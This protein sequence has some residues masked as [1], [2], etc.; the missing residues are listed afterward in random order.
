MEFNTAMSQAWKDHADD[1]RGVA[2]RLPALLPLVDD[3]AQLERLVALTHHVHGTHL[4]QW[5]AGAEALA[6]LRTLNAY[7]DDGR[8]G[9]ALRRALASLALC[10]GKMPATLPLSLSDQVRV[11]AMAAENLGEHDPARA[12]QLF[13]TTLDLAQRSG[14]PDSDA[15]HRAIA[16]TANGLA[17]ALEAK[18]DRSADD[19]ALMILA[20]QA[21][22][23][24]WERAGTWLEV[25]RAEYRL[26]M[27]WLQ[28]GDL[29]Q[30]RQHG[31]TCREIVAENNGGALER[32]FGWEAL[33]RVER[34]AD[35]EV[36]HAHA[37]AMA[38]EAFSELSV[39][40]QAW[41]AASLDQLAAAA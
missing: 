20:A 12:G 13:R 15:M 37:L 1:A 35:N 33:G 11:H 21:A 40:D 16:I 28:A 30:A 36:G 9:Q 29:G 14:L 2:I 23:R 18:T 6:P 31:Q 27:S 5:Q 41:C 26:A 38:R 19:R 22:R 3:E 39:D 7:Q 17:C 34:A 32:L 24:H 10:E 25:E 8:S 4:G